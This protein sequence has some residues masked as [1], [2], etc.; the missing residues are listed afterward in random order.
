MMRVLL[1]GGIASGKST[2]ALM[3][4]K[5]GAK[6]LTCDEISRNLVI[7]GKKGLELIVSNFGKQFLNIDGL[8]NRK[9]FSNFIFKNKEKLDTL[10]NLLHPLINKRINKKFSKLEFGNSII[11]VELPLLKS[12]FNNLNKHLSFN[13]ISHYKS[14]YNITILVETSLKKRILRMQKN[15]LMNMKDIYLILKQQINRRKR[16]E[17]ADL[18]IHNSGSIENTNKQVNEIWSKLLRMT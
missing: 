13:F 14:N 17:V 12:M 3:F 16:L 9:K 11:I 7:P 10:N 8:L 5:L 18:I 4:R 6:I 15:R 2:V 1:V